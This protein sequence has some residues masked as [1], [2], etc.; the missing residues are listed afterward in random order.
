[1]GEVGH[2][3]ITPDSMRGV[4]ARRDKGSILLHILF[5]YFIYK[6]EYPC[7]GRGDCPRMH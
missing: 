7:R 2:N 3:R 5:I 1:M 6:D 4:Q